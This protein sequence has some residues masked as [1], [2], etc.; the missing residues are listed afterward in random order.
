[1]GKGVINHTIVRHVTVSDLNG[2]YLVLNDYPPGSPLG[3]PARP[4]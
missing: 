3:P 1:V 2:F 4:E